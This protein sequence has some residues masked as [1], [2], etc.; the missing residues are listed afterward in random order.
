[1]IVVGGCMVLVGTT[2]WVKVVEFVRGLVKDG[3]AG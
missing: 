1:M 2:V 3:L